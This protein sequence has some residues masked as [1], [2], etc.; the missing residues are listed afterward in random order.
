M[1]RDAASAPSPATEVF[2]R[3]SRRSNDSLFIGA[4]ECNNGEARYA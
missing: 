3:K 4:P 2:F 1:L